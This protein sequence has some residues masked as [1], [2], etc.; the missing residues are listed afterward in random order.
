MDKSTSVLRLGLR[1]VALPELFSGVASLVV[2]R[3]IV[4][5]TA[6]G[7]FPVV[8]AKVLIHRNKS[9]SPSIVPIGTAVYVPLADVPRL[10]SRIPEALA[11]RLHLGLELHIIDVD[12]VRKRVLASQDACPC[13]AANR[14]PRDHLI[15]ADTF[16]GE[17]IENRS[18]DIGIAR[19]AERLCPPFVGNQEQY[20]RLLAPS[21]GLRSP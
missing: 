20:V 16:P 11:E 10:I 4:I 12:P 15:E 5:V 3:L 18:H 1:V 7:H 6:L 17:L 14:K 21:P 13:R 2:K 9:F 19:I 8:K